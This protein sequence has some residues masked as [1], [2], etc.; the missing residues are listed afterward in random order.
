MWATNLKVIAVVL[1]T[2][3]VYTLICNKIP[4]MQSEVPVRPNIAANTTPDQLVAW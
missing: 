3:F 4:Q 1:G 2:L